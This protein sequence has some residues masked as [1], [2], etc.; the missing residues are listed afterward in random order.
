MNFSEV[1]QFDS[2]V[3]ERA[4]Q[5]FIASS[6]INFNGLPILENSLI[7]NDGKQ[8]SV[9]ILQY[10]A[11]QSSNK[12]IYNLKNLLALD[13]EKLVFKVDKVSSCQNEGVSLDIGE[14]GIWHINHFDDVTGS[15]S[16]YLYSRIQEKS[17]DLTYD[18][19]VF[20][21]IFY[22]FDYQS[23]ELT[24]FINTKPVTINLG[25]VNV[26]LPEYLEIHKNKDCYT[27]VP[28]VD[29]T[30]QVLQFAAGE[31]LTL[32]F[33]GILEGKVSK[34]FKAK[35]INST[36]LKLVTINDCSYVKIT[37]DG[38][39]YIN[40]FDNDSKQ[41]KEYNL[42]ILKMTNK[43]K[44][45]ISFLHFLLNEIKNKKVNWDEDFVRLAVRHYPEFTNDGKHTWRKIDSYLKNHKVSKRAADILNNNS[46]NIKDVHYEHIIPVKC[47]IEKLKKLLCLKSDIPKSDIEEIMSECE[48]MIISKEEKSILDGSLKKSYNIDNND[49][50][51]LG[52]KTNCNASERIKKLKKHIE[53]EFNE[54]YMNNSLFNE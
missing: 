53:F 30:Y 54:K 37:T 50:K 35:I 20:S 16:K 12:E 45:I 27:I 6:D 40:L 44:N 14:T 17:V 26:T 1:F 23:K 46:N 11:F 5:L 15:W 3:V 10:G 25:N 42:E 43:Q 48:V 21:H 8:I 9:N 38:L 36:K 22:H 39:V 49:C 52:L 41:K 19:F 33:N 47:T 24:S 7:S 51:G 4:T 32:Y 31:A 28:L 13:D 29:I 34:P 2:K 18:G